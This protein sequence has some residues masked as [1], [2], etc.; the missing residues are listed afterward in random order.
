MIKESKLCKGVVF[1]LNS[2][3]N[4]SSVSNCVATDAV[5]E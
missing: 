1:K 2:P 5:V 4:R 3:S